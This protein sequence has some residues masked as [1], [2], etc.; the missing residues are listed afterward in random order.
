VKTIRRH[1]RTVAG[2]V[3][4]KLVTLLEETAATVLHQALQALQLPAPVGVAESLHNL[5]LLAELVVVVTVDVETLVLTCR[6][7]RPLGQSTLEAVAE[8]VALEV[9]LVW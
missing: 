9:V 7:L 2:A 1:F 5:C 3:L 6:L 4:R 8:V